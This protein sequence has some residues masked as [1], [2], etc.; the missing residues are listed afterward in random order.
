MLKL[1]EIYVMDCLEGL[2]LLDDNSINCCVTSPPYWNLRD[3]GVKPTDWPAVSYIPMAGLP[4]ISIPAWTGC[5][6]L[7]PT[8]EKF[9]GHTVAV[10]REVWRVLRKDGT[11]W[12]NFGDSYCSTAPGTMGDNVHIH[13][14][15]ETTK[16]A[17][18]TMRTETPNGLKVKDLIGIPWRVAFALQADGWYLRQDIIW[19]KPNPMPES[20]RGPMH[21]GT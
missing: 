5:L 2:K 6:G 11:L 14:T 17:K 12:I 7:E 19:A 9:V 1:N 8:V 15:K 20:V 16:R 13:G 3:Y 21:Q 10:F 18:K 4:P